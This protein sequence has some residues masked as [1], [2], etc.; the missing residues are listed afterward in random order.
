MDKIRYLEHIIDKDGGR[1]YPVRDTTIKIMP[2]PENV[3]ALQSFLGLANYYQ[4]FIPNMYN[5]RAPVNELLKKDEDWEW[6]PKWQ[7]AFVN[8]K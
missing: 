3:T 1:P 6:T 5:L 8:I 7:E 4:V 2:V